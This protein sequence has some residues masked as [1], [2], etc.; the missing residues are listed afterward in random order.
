[1][2]LT[3]LGIWAFTNL[4]TAYAVLRVDERAKAYLIASLANVLLTVVLTLT[5]VVVLDKGAHGILLGNYVASAVVL[6]AMWI[7]LRRRLGVPSTRVHLGPM[8]RFGLPTVPAEVSVFLLNVIDRFYIY[9]TCAGGPPRRAC[10]RS[11]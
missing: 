8:L 2:W 9:R 6:I 7:L 11:P 1:M 4:E 10:S 3:A 5:L